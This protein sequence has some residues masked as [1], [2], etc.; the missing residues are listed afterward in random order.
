MGSPTAGEVP[1]T[2]VPRTPRPENAMPIRFNHLS[3]ATPAALD[4][5]RWIVVSSRLTSRRVERGTLRYTFVAPRDEADCTDLYIAEVGD[6]RASPPTRTRRIDP[7]AKFA[8]VPVVTSN[9]TVDTALRLVRGSGP[10]TREA[11]LYLVAYGDDHRQPYDVDLV[12]LTS[13]AL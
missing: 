3:T 1:A 6:P 2:T 8:D 11:R 7:P 10:P 5:G 9:G 12:R 4:P 13:G